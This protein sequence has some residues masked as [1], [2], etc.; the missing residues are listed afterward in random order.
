[1]AASLAVDQ[2]TR[3]QYL[4]VLCG[5]FLLSAVGLTRPPIKL[6][7]CHRMEKLRGPLQQAGQSLDQITRTAREM[8]LAS[9]TAHQGSQARTRG[10]Y[11]VS[12]LSDSAR[13]G[14][15]PQGTVA[16]VE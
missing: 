7:K 8:E 2:K 3:E 6:T 5:W 12:W 9:F 13:V 15:L 1:M 14:E 10:K 16:S 4:G 11:A